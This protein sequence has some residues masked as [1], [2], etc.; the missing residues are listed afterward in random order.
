MR[1]LTLLFYE[2]RHAHNRISHKAVE[3]RRNPLSILLH[4]GKIA[5]EERVLPAQRF[6]VRAIIDDAEARAAV[7]GRA[8]TGDGGVR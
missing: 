5:A 6:R 8:W 2:L 1:P 3:I 4:A 7:V